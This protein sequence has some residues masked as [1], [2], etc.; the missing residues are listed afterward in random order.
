MFR[1]S[2]ILLF[3]CWTSI[4][5]AQSDAKTDYKAAYLSGDFEKCEDLTTKAI[6]VNPKD[7]AAFYFR[8]SA[9]VEIGFIN[10]D[11]KQLRA[12][13]EDA[14]ESLKIGGSS[15][16]D[17]YLPYLLGMISLSVNEQKR[18]FAET[19]LEQSKNVLSRASL[20]PEQ[21]ANILYQRG[22]AHMVL[23]DMNAG[24]D[25][26]QQAIKAYPKHIG[27]Y[28]K[29]AECYEITGQSDKALAAFTSAIEAFPDSQL[30]FNNRGLFLQKQNKLPESLA[31]LSKAI[32][33]DKNF[34]LAY[35]NRG[36]TYQ[37]MGN[38]P[39][40]EADFTKA[41]GLETKNPIIY[42][43]RGSCRVLKGNAAGAIEDYTRAIQMDPR[44]Y[45]AYAD[46]GFAKFFSKDYAGATADFDQS[47]K[48]NPEAMR[49]LN[50]WRVWTRTLS[51][52]TDGVAEIV[53][54]SA[55][56]PEK[57]R[58]WIDEQV[59]FIGGK[60]S[61]KALVEYVSKEANP[62]LPK[63]QLE[64]LKNGELCEAYFFIAE[65]R[66]KV[67]D[68]VNAELFYKQVLL[69]KQAHLSAYRGAQFALN[70]FGG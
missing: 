6:A 36:Y 32:E 7:H 25:E 48:M 20:T 11:S 31:D 63:E 47:T 35:T 19:A 13:I 50:P 16:V 41:L 9:R 60:L 68:T 3:L 59:L 14:R 55:D 49:F 58:D 62:N 54:A 12:G 61:E 4:A 46:L 22:T 53:Q 15:N 17:Y 34:A 42:S 2:A 64:N 43:L 1:C 51:G 8:A 26:F 23:S 52:N 38:L 65:L 40:A 29:L 66:S 37:K 57:D 69:T 18:E 21:R 45:V 27:S 56:K 24:V 5:A 67:K 30:A 28:M 10:H 33:L 39:Q 44:N 70:S